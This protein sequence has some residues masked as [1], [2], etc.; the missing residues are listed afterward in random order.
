MQ[1]WKLTVGGP[2]GPTGCAVCVAGKQGLASLQLLSLVLLLLCPR[3]FGTAPVSV[4][5]DFVKKKRSGVDG[6]TAVMNHCLGCLR[7]ISE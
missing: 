3:V 5:H 4:F 6:W 2:C 1:F 7:P